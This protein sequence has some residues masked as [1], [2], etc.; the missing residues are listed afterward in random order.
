MSD[1][2][3]AELR[4]TGNLPSPAGVGLRILQ[5]TQ[6]ED[7]SIEEVAAVLQ[8][9]PTLTGRLLKLANSGS[10]AGRS[11]AT[12]ARAAAVR[13]GLK[14]V[15]TISLGFSLLAGNRHGRCRTFDYDGFWSHSLCVAACAQT[16]EESRAA[17]PPTEAFTCGLLHGMGRL[18]LAS[19]HP[20]AYEAV[21]ESARDAS[22]Q[23]LAE[24]EAEA[25]GIDHREVGAAMLRDWR[26]PEHYAVAVATHGTGALPDPSVGPLALGLA[27]SLSDARDLA[28]ALMLDLDASADACARAAEILRQL[29]A[30][31]ELDDAGLADL[32]TRAAKNWAGWG[33]PMGI[34]SKAAIGLLEIKKRAAIAREAAE[35]GRP[36]DT[37][38]IVPARTRSKELRVLL[39]GASLVRSSGLREILASDGHE[40]TTAETGP[41]ALTAAL[42]VAPHL[43]L[44]DWD[45]SDVKAGELLRTLRLSE[46]GNRFQFVVVADR[47]REARLLDA[48]EAGADEFLLR[49]FDARLV[50]ARARAAL[51]FVQMDEQVQDL[52]AERETQIGQMAILAR[53]LQ[54]AS[55]TDGPT[56]VYTRRHGVERM[57][58]VFDAAR[59]GSTDVT[60]LVLSV[61]GCREIRDDH[62]HAAC[63]AVLRETARVASG[64]VR[65][66]DS[67][68]RL[69]GEDFVAIC[70]GS[71]LHAGV[72]IAERLRE[73][74][75]ANV[76]RW[77]QFEGAV[78]VSIGVASLE[79]SHADAEALLRSAEQRAK[80][81]RDA[82]G[83]RVVASPPPELLRAT[84]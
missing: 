63:D 14:S 17:L 3:F 31:L 27:R 2:H 28:H 72:E 25:F 82:G 19:V 57:A 55:A 71:D 33:G 51:R 60:L 81:A 53:K 29:Q 69:G 32:W 36:A 21:L 56:G 70:P 42:D 76:V 78:T 26:M 52:L 67:V 59:T 16:I 74:V 34:R 23:V 35:R 8:T 13:L 43:V 73:G 50:R 68:C 7:A 79:R 22:T 62:G 39:V 12:T 18:A 5:L 45:A 65:K 54:I 47:G 48:F 4:L 46:F 84:G 6:R 44:C 37:T 41:E 77:A 11:V 10:A 64:L 61:D 58:K 49:P 9:D 1:Q 30:R 38:P 80:V 24:H 40:I 20:A 15:R 75:A 83:D 66:G